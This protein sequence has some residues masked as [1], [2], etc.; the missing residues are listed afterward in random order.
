MAPRTPPVPNLGPPESEPEDQSDESR[1][2]LPERE[3]LVAELASTAE[4]VDAAARY[5]PLDRRAVESPE[6]G[7]EETVTEWIGPGVPGSDGDVLPAALERLA[8]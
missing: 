7:R 1:V 3:D 2:A 4:D 8:E 5:L 6:G